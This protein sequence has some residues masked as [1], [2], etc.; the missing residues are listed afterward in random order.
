MAQARLY[1]LAAKEAYRMLEPFCPVPASNSTPTAAAIRDRKEKEKN[2][3]EEDIATSTA[4]GESNR[5]TS[6]HNTH[7]RFRRLIDDHHTHTLYYLAQVYG[8]LRQ[9]DASASY[10]FQTLAKQV[11]WEEGRLD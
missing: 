7:S 9:A 11:E 6:I 1:L 10:C 8:Q 2:E 4:A 5:S 3:E